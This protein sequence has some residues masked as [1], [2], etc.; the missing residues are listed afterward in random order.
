[1]DLMNT[2]ISTKFTEAEVL[3]IFVDVVEAVV[4]MHGQCDIDDSPT[5]VLVNSRTLMGCSARPQRCSVRCM[6]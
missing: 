2:K 5:S 6:G 3:A 1:M 4:A